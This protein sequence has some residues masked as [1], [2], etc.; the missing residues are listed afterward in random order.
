MTAKTTIQRQ[1]EFK[2]R[3]REAGLKEVRNLW[4]P[5]ADHPAIKAY[6]L[7]LQKPKG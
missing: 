3:Q 1:K 4:A 6:A 5:P 2:Q 7:A